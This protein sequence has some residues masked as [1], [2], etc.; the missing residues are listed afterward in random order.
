[1]DL[2]YTGFFRGIGRDLIMFT[3][4]H[5]DFIKFRNF[6]SNWLIFL[7]FCSN[8]SFSSPSHLSGSSKIIASFLWISTWPITLKQSFWV[9]L[10]KKLKVS[11]SYVSVYI[12]IYIDANFYILSRKVLLVNYHKLFKV[13]I[14]YFQIES[15]IPS[16]NYFNDHNF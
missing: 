9:S 8:S 7:F 13:I 2:T 15:K 16:K 6:H 4:S 3:Y 14:F 10:L 1:M 11:I 5:N 12:R